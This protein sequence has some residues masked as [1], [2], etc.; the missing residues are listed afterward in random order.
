M[1][2]ARPFFLKT[3]LTPN[4]AVFD[5]LVNASIRGVLEGKT[6]SVVLG[7]GVIS[8][9]SLHFRPSSTVRM[10]L[11]VEWNDAFHVT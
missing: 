3:T 8:V 4:C 10:F 2:V 5:D 7:H 6:G 1:C 11:D 9:Q